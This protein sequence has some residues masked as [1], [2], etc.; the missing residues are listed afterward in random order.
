MCCAFF[1]HGQET[2]A[3]VDALALLKR[4]LRFYIFSISTALIKVQYSTYLTGHRSECNEQFPHLHKLQGL[5]W[6]ICCWCISTTKKIVEIFIF[7]I[8][9]ALIKLQYSTYLTGHR[10]EC[11]LQ[12]PH[13]YK[14]QGLSFETRRSIERLRLYWLLFWCSE[15]SLIALWL[16]AKCSLGAATKPKKT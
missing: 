4:L 11:K 7:S 2:I 13:L 10:S 5:I 14:L 9:T 8:S 12:F 15:C 1:R 16:L 3:L 6:K